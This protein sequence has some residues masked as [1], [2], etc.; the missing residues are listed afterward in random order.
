MPDNYVVSSEHAAKIA[1][2]IKT[3]GGIAIWESLSLTQANSQTTPVHKADGTPSTK[4]HWSMANAPAR[5]I[6]DM[7]EVT[8]ANDV[9]VKRF[10][11]ATRMGAQG[12]ALKVTD[13]GSRRIKREV[14]EGAYYVFDYG[15]EENAVIMKPASMVPL[16]EWLN[17]Q[18]A[19]GR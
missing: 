6:T 2:W 3:R 10:H 18:T 16:A 14:A 13:G 11:V 12:M 9:V 8:V 5:I 17:N 19:E 1:E 15:S 7:A 4:P